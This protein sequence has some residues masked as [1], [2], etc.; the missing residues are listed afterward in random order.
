[1]QNFF[2]FALY[3]CLLHFNLLFSSRPSLYCL[4]VGIEPFSF[5][6]YHSGLAQ[7]SHGRFVQ[8]DDIGNLEEVRNTQRRTET[9]AASGGQDMAGAGNIIA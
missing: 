9:S 8:G 7:F 2:I 3:F 4:G 1:M 6:Y 5:S